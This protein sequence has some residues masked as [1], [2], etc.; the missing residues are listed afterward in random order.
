[1]FTSAST[2]RSF[3]ATAGSFSVAVTPT[4]TAIRRGPNV[5]LSWAAVTVSSGDIV[6]YRVMRTSPGLA[7][8]QICTGAD[9]PVTSGGVVTCIDRKPGATSTY[10]AQ[11]YVVS[12]T[13]AETWSLTPSPSVSA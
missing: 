11:A 6:N 1:M 9:A 13:G 7:A 3:S 5:H 10:T 8:V 4:P 2:T 12:T